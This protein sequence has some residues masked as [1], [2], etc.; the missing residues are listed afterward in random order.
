MFGWNSQAKLQKLVEQ[1]KFS[2]A[3]D[4]ASKMLRASPHNMI[5]RR[6]RA[7]CYLEMKEYQSALKD[8]YL[9]LSEDPSDPYW[10][11]LLAFVYS[12]KG[13]PNAA[14][15]I[16]RSVVNAN[17]TFSRLFNY[18]VMLEKMNRYEEAM[19]I[20][21]RLGNERFPDSEDDIEGHRICRIHVAM[22]LEFGFDTE[23]MRD[24]ELALAPEIRNAYN[25]MAENGMLSKLVNPEALAILPNKGMLS[26]HI[27]ANTVDGYFEG[28]AR[29]T[30][31]EWIFDLKSES[32]K[33][34]AAKAVEKPSA[35]AIDWISKQHESLLTHKS[36]LERSE[37]TNSQII[38]LFDI[39]RA[40]KKIE[41]GTYGSCELCGKPIPRSRL[42]DLP[43]T[44]YHVKCQSELAAC[45]ALG[46][47][48]PPTI[49]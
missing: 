9:G 40:L 3:V 32:E 8:I 1:K 7:N 24:A 36:F 37:K 46:R 14:V 13:H 5:L 26:F 16:L 42:K 28:E 30:E 2:E 17:P 15:A 20:Y 45:W 39:D 25:K 23:R 49:L 38:D 34:P 27:M 6:I 41:D 43:S 22:R 35:N 47:N 19:V 10:I 48:A 31:P 29:R 4:V 21:Q 33:K 11:M 44:R 12:D 18:A